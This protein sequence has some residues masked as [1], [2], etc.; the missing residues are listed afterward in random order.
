MLSINLVDKK[1]L[2]LILNDV[3]DKYGYDFT[4][5]SSASILRRL[6]R[7]CSIDK[8]TSF[9]ELRY[10]IKHDEEYFG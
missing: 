2:E 1:E 5:Y 7:L 4:E 6:N 10:K 3:A 9:A 8:F